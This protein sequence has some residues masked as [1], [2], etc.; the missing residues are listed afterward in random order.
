MST[1]LQLGVPQRGRLAELEAI[2]ER[3]Q[4]TFLEVGRALREIRDGRLYKKNYS[5]FEEYCQR[6]WG[7]GRSAAYAYMEAEEYVASLPEFVH[8][9]GQNFTK[10]QALTAARG[11]MD[12]HYSSETPEWYTPPEIITRTQKT[13]GKIDLDPCS[14]PENTVP[15]TRSFSKA[16]DGLSF[17]WCG[18]VYMNPPYGREIGAW[19]EKLVAEHKA[20]RT[21]E[22]IALVPARVDTDWFRTFRDF[23]VCFV[24]G[25]LKFSGHEN[26]APFPSAAVYLG[27]NV[28]R[29]AKSFGDMGDV[30]VRWP[31]EGRLVMTLRTDRD[32][33][34]DWLLVVGVVVIVIVAALYWPKRGP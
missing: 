15:A 19:V 10:N 27:P 28:A 17:D 20:G 2:V 24:D 11:G 4:K 31:A 30:W 5:T 32:S 34:R 22:A 23:V 25:R 1:L 29:F 12:V 21:K 26:S 7:M 3:G 18:R 14:G 6:R 16:D 33:L 9:R 8:D 13:L